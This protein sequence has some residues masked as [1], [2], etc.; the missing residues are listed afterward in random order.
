MEK[1]EI[2]KKLLESKGRHLPCKL[3]DTAQT[4][5]A[6]QEL[7]QEGLLESKDAENA[8]NRVSSAL[9]YL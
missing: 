1:K 3:S 5:T 8:T 2:K 6:I 9:D 7:K 4:L